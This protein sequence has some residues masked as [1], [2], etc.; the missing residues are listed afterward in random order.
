MLHDHWPRGTKLKNKCTPFSKIDSYLRS[1]TYQ[2][3]LVEAWS[4]AC[5]N[6]V[7]SLST[8]CLTDSCRKHP[9][10]CRR[11]YIMVIISSHLT[12]LRCKLNPSLYSLR[13][14]TTI[15]Y[16]VI[17]IQYS[18][19]LCSDVCMAKTPQD[20]DEEKEYRQAG[21]EVIND[22]PYFK[23]LVL[24]TSCAQR[25]LGQSST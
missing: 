17:C 7:V 3:P 14:E 2:S 10:T 12:L 19:C 22:T 5:I 20:A 9:I 21:N 16:S 18:L 11:V 4:H 8:G 6:S 15:V 23:V 1:W 24:G 13:C 25:P